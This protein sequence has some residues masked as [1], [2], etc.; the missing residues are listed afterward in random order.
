MSDTVWSILLTQ[1][2]IAIACLWVAWEMRGIHRALMRIAT[3]VDKLTKP[4]TPP[5]PPPSVPPVPPQRSGP[6]AW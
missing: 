2:P 3:Q 6:A 4:E 5:V 1:T